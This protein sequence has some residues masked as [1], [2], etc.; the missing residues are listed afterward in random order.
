[1]GNDTGLDFI[2]IPDTIINGD[3]MRYRYTDREV[4]DGLEYTY[5]VVAYDMGVEPP[6]KT[7]YNNSGNGQFVAV[8]DTNHSNPDQWANPDGYASIENS[9]GTT[10]LDRNFVQVY[11]GVKPS[12]TVN[13]IGVVPN[14]YRVNSGF[15]ESEHMRQIRF[16]N[17]PARCTIKIFTLNGEAVSTVDHDNE[18]SGNAWW[19]MRTVNNQEVAPGLYLFHVVDNDNS[20][21]DPYIGKFAVIR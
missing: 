8:V 18:E 5:S 20:G 9:K 15:K 7:T 12:L 3:T 16:T 17:L 1:L 11:P 13:D 21:S 6:F 14:P 10:V 4:I 19:D 2:R